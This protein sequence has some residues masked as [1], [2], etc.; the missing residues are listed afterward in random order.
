MMRLVLV[1]VVMNKANT[2]VKGYILK[3][4]LGKQK[5]FTS[6]AV[7]DLLYKGIRVNG[8]RL[9]RDGRLLR[10]VAYRKREIAS[11][12]NLLIY[13]GNRLL[14]RCKAQSS[15]FKKRDFVEK[16]VRFSLDGSV[17]NRIMLLH[18]LRRTGKTTAIHHAIMELINR[19]VSI[20]S[21]ICLI[22]VINNSTTF[23]EIYS[24]LLRISKHLESAIVFIDEI[25]N[26]VDLIPNFSKLSDQLY[27]L[28]II[29]SGTDSYVFPTASKTTLFGRCLSIHTTLLSYNE[30]RKLVADSSLNSYITDGSLSGQEFV[31]NNHAVDAVNSAIIGNINSTILR[32]YSFFNTD[33][34]FDYSWLTKL[35]QQEL[36]VITYSILSS[37]VEH[38]S[39]KNLVSIIRVI[40]KKRAEFIGEAVGIGSNEIPK[41]LNGI[42]NFTINNMIKLISELDVI[43][44]LNNLATMLCSDEQ[45]NN[46]YKAETD[47]EVCILLPGLLS[48]LLNSLNVQQSTI[49][50]KEIENLVIISLYCI[51][52]YKGFKVD[53]VGY[54][55]YK[56]K[57]VEHEVD[58]VV[59]VFD[60]NHIPHYTLIEVKANSNQSTT[61][62]KHLITPDLPEGLRDKGVV[63]V[64]VYEG[65]TDMSGYIKYINIEDFILNPW[66][67]II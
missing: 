58:I 26:V 59:K 46:G 6:S 30:Y 34:H 37:V 16:V 63:R 9:G 52:G 17:T 51:E 21:N 10:E 38:R 8:M 7:K 32:N 3:D 29:V 47:K 15:G 44:Q 25:T 57:E 40:G 5:L 48:T 28:K 56:V 1:K 67:Y 36:S 61:F 49:I 27:N 62:I 60:S 24:I 65:K 23:N 13:S 33:K 14:E 19:Q 41:K 35:S 4:E 31:G 11:T 54:L 53:T 64:V 2:R 18:G 45:L 55:K 66:L 12:K 39:N 42:N 22:E 20:I 43:R 50:G